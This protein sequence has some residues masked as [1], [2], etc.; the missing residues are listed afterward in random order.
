GLRPVAA[1]DDVDVTRAA[2]DD[3]AGLRPCSLDERIDG[4]GR[5]VDQLVDGGGVEPALL[6]AIDHSL[7]QMRRGGEALRL[8]E[9]LCALVKSDEIREGAPDIDGDDHHAG[10]TRD[11]AGLPHRT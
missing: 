11:C 5:A 7:H 4:D 2:G 8:D 6:D 9:A 3:E 10:K 1:A